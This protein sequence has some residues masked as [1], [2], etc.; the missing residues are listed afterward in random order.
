M[1]ATKYKYVYISAEKK[2]QVYKQIQDLSHE[3]IMRCE[4]SVRIQLKAWASSICAPRWHM[5]IWGNHTSWLIVLPK[6]LRQLTCTRKLKK[7][8]NAS[9]VWTFNSH[10]TAVCT[11]SHD[12]VFNIYL[13]KVVLRISPTFFSL[14]SSSHS[15][16]SNRLVVTWN[17]S[18]VKVMWTLN[19]CSQR[20][21]MSEG[22]KHRAPIFIL[23]CTPLITIWTRAG[24]KVVHNV[25]SS[26]IPFCKQFSKCHCVPKKCFIAKRIRI[27][28]S[29]LEFNLQ[30]P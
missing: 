20:S 15:I 2:F 11:S 16:S 5:T 22:T 10:Y 19:T 21:S 25:N 8:C 24:S 6:H 13:F 26:K 3:R 18:K 14:V 27:G 9:Q 12:W 17:G 4:D 28:Q 30:V 29:A 1:Y 23:L 7:S